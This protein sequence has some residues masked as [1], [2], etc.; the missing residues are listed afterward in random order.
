MIKAMLIVTALSG[1]V[2]YTTEMPSMESCLKAR[3]AITMQDAS[4]KTLCVPKEDE[5]KKIE[6]FFQI[7]MN[8]IDQIKEYEELDRLENDRLYR[9]EEDCKRPFG[10]L[11][12]EG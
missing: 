12:C 5:S 8:M 11:E 2:D 9:P 1:G 3:D 7:F 10:A 4:L 6:T